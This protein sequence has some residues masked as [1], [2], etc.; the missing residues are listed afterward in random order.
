VGYQLDFQEQIV[1][2]SA[3]GGNLGSRPINAGK[4]MHKGGEMTL[5]FDIGKFLE[6]NYSLALETNSSIN[7]AV[8]NQY[9]YNLSAL[10]QGSTDHLLQKD[11]NGKFLPYVSREVHII[12][13]SLGL[14]SGF[15]GRVDYQHFSKQFNDLS[16]TKTVYWY[17]TAD[18]NTKSFLSYMNIASDASGTNGEVPEIGLV[19]ASLGYRSQSGRW[20]IFM[21]GKNLQDRSYISTRLPEGIQPGPRRQINIGI[22]LD[23]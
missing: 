22:S 10:S 20:S 16:N 13:L 3:A 21:N 14:P 23:L 1:N 2:S 8:S 11:T 9:T 17:D 6:K 7:H 12:G 19:N 5:S 4:S 15:Y 18:T